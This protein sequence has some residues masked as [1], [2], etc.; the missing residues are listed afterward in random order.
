[1][2]GN[3]REEKLTLSFELFSLH[4]SHCCLLPQ[5][6]QEVKLRLELLE[7][8]RN[9]RRLLHPGDKNRGGCEERVLSF[10]SF[11]LAAVL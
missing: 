2:R 3:K 8:L 5:V 6:G 11:S 4:R 10:S 7:E 9:T 1:M